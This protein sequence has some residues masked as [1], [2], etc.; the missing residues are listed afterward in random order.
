MTRVPATFDFLSS[1]ISRL[2]LRQMSLVLALIETR[3]LHRAAESLNLSQPAATKL[4]QEIER[5]LGVSLFDRQPRGMVPTVYGMAA[6]RHARLLLRDLHRLQQEMEGLKRGIAG[7]VHLGSVMAAVPRLIAGALASISQQHPTLRVSL[8]TDTSDALLAELHGGRLDVV[9]GRPISKRDRDSLTWEPL[10][11]EEIR[12]VV[13]ANNPL[14]ARRG[15]TLADLAQ[16]N[17]VMQ[18]DTTPMRHTI[19]AAFATAGLDLPRHSVETV[20]MLAT[21]SLLAQ[22][23]MVGSV[24]DS[25]A[26]YFIALGTLAELPVELPAG[27]EPCGLITLADRPIGPALECLMTTLRSTAHQL[28]IT[29]EPLEPMP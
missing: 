1:T 14:L 25:I 20:S 28:R 22:T 26:S 16:E 27:M 5:T 8:L 9:V 2:K 15:L 4:L 19:E 29:S 12:I 6:A 3:N 23:G 21:A 24:P 13:G 18:Q 11:D 10:L 7:T 17:W